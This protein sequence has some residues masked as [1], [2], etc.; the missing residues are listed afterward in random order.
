[1]AQIQRLGPPASA[2]LRID[3]GDN[4]H[5]TTYHRHHRANRLNGRQLVR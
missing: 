2:A 4:T 5:L 3:R 1:M